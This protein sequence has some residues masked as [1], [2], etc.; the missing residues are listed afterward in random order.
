MGLIIPAR[1][2]CSVAAVF[3]DGR[4]DTARS[5]TID[6]FHDHGGMDKRAR[7][8][9]AL[10]RV[11]AVTILHAS[12]TLHWPQP[13]QAPPLWDGW[14]LGP[15]LKRNILVFSFEVVA[16]EKWDIISMSPERCVSMKYNKEVRSSA[17][18]VI[19]D[20]TAYVVRYSYRALSGIAVVSMSI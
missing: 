8:D 12:S 6:R 15:G 5:P 2:L 9:A 1:S 11:A 18:A 17:V 3:H 13:A 14:Y 19:A 7:V 4:G 16:E 10:R 20:R